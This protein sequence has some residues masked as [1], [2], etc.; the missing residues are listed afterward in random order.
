MQRRIDTLFDSLLPHGTLQERELNV[1]SL[2]NKY[3]S[4]MIDWLYGAVDLND[5]NHRVVNF[6]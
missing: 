5:K 6:K 2:L 1:I 4:P 3:G